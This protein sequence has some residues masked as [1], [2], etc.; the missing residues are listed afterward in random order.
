[1]YVIA[2]FARIWNIAA[3]FV[4]RSED[5]EQEIPRKPCE[6]NK[7]FHLKIRALIMSQL[8]HV[9]CF[10]GARNRSTLEAHK[11]AEVRKIGPPNLL[12]P[13]HSGIFEVD[14]F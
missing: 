2:V 7:I 12:L 14:S 5:C 10:N 6:F 9:S 3:D 1:M 8:L 4:F 13:K 11:G